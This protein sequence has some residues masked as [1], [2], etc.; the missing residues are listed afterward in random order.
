VALS[1]FLI[2]CSLTATVGGLVQVLDR[3]L[4]DKI[5]EAR[6]SMGSAS[7]PLLM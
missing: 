7:S 3:D 2:T 4:G 6:V 1:M 5:E